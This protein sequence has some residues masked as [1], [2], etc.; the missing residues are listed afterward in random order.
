[1]DREQRFGQMMFVYMY[2]CMYASKSVCVVWVFV[3]SNWTN[4][5]ELRIQRRARNRSG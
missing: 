4:G 5:V 3:W 1:M 2:V